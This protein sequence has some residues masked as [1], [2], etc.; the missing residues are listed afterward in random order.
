LA[1]LPL[2]VT[3]QVQTPTSLP[4]QD[5]EAVPVVLPRS[6]SS[7]SLRFTE[8][9]FFTNIARISGD[10]RERSFLTNGSNNAVDLNY[11]Q[12]FTLGS[13]RVE[14]SSLLRYT[15][16]RRY[17]PERSSVQRASLR[18][19]GQRSEYNFGDYLV[20]YSRFSYNQNLKGVHFARTLPWRY[21]F[22]LLGNAGTFTDRYGSLFKDEIPG[23]PF[24]RV[25]AGLRAEQRV[26][27]EK[28]IGVNWAYGSDIAESL[29][30][31]PVTGRTPFQPIANQVVSF[32]ARMYLAH[33]WNLD[34]EVAFS[35]TSRDTLNN[36]DYDHDYAVRIDNSVRTSAGT[37]SVFYTRV[38]PHFLAINARQVAD[39][40]DLLARASI[41]LG[42]RLQIQGIYRRAANDLRGE[43]P[44]KQ[45]VF[46]TPEVRLSLRNLPGL[47]DAA[48]E[49]GYRE[50][51]YNQE[52]LTNRVSRTPFFEIGL[53]ITSGMLTMG[54]EHRRTNDRQGG[55]NDT[56]AN[57]AWINLRNVLDVGDWT[58]MPVARYQHNRESFSRVDAHNNTRTILAAL[59]LDAPRYVAFDFVFRQVGA[60]LFQDRPVI[61]QQTFQ[62][63][64]DDKGVQHFEVIGPSGFRRPALRAAITYKFQN[65]SNR[66]LTFSYERSNNSFAVDGQDFLESVV[67]ATLTLRLSER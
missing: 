36:D 65:N 40:E 54:Y 7:S 3:A 15:D 6:Q 39:L 64:L 17:D 42:S 33:K 63:V 22:R 55:N 25:V 10:A 21:G 59:T 30:L 32:D 23:K 16:D 14:A 38:L 18:V 49:V 35:R 5:E 28:T 37:F 20:S 57:D 53:P 29:P 62:P 50:R 43:R 44:D 66:F 58:F 60:T 41:P 27:P 12:E 46:H 52:A 34:G 67:Q 47:V 9:R 8:L 1:L 56:V 45:T 2:V 48:L 13:R 61:D 26:A 51:Y 31:D 19:I 24:T 4:G 11:L